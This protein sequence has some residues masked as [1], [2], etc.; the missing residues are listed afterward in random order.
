VGPA[1]GPRE[2]SVSK[3]ARKA[4][5]DRGFVRAA[6]R[7]PDP[8]GIICHHMY[9]RCNAMSCWSLPAVRRATGVATE[10]TG[11]AG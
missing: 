9:S 5:L 4:S 3:S 7:D 1:F 11:I 10:A 8:G 2:G 6:L